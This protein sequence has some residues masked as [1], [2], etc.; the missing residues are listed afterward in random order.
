[1]NNWR[2]AR[3]R[4]LGGRTWGSRLEDCVAVVDDSKE[5]L[6][7]LRQVLSGAGFR[8]ATAEDGMS[9][10]TLVRRVRPRVLVLDLLMPHMSGYEV[11]N[12]IRE[13][14]ALQG[15]AIVVVTGMARDEAE[16]HDMGRGADLC[17]TKPVDEP[18]LLEFVR[19]VFSGRT[20]DPGLLKH[21]RQ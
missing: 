21:I 16:L 7:T 4:A 15:I 20:Q 3:V 14:P 9:G 17:L 19:E 1:M 10:L 11:I 13:D 2:A 12:A 6:A 8:V 18:R 5:F